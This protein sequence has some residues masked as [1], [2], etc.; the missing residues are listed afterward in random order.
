[1]EPTVKPTAR[2]A[3]RVPFSRSWRATAR[4]ACL[5][6]CEALRRSL[7][8]V[9]ADL[10]HP[11]FFYEKKPDTPF[12]LENRGERNLTIYVSATAIGK[13]FAEAGGFPSESELAQRRAVPL[14]LRLRRE[15]GEELGEYA[16]QL[17]RR[18]LEAAHLDIEHP[19]PLYSVYIFLYL[20]KEHV[21]PQSQNMF[22]LILFS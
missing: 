6:D 19:F 13:N 11:L 17:R 5:V 22:P 14:S 3:A 8:G 1:M 4:T 7:Q 2:R 16:H 9:R 20:E 12:I 18:V 15:R 10:P 21:L